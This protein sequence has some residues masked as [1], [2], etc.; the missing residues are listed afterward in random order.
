MNLIRWRPYQSLLDS[1]PDIWE[2]DL[3]TDNNQRQKLNIYEKDNELVVEANVAGV[4]ADQIDL[5]FDKGILWIKAEAEKEEGQKDKKHYS[6]AS[7]SYSYK[8]A[9][10]GQIDQQSEPKAELSK[11]ILKIKFKKQAIAEPKKLKITEKND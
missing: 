8:V 3:L 5:S 2:D 7:W 1:W 11:G 9:V 10:P 6:K 4:K